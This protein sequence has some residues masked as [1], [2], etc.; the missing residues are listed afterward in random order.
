MKTDKPKT[1][2]AIVPSYLNDIARKYSKIK[3]IPISKVVENALMIYL[4]DE[5]IED[6]IL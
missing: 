5:L 2:T 1:I 3:K 6:G 4:V